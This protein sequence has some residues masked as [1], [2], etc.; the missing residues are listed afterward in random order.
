MAQI[1][2]SLGGTS[3]VQL[4]PTKPLKGRLVDDVA[5]LSQGSK[6]PIWGAFLSPQMIFYKLLRARQL[7][8]TGLGDFAQVVE[9]QQHAQQNFFYFSA[10]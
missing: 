7:G 1:V 5:L 4:V 6:P 3:F 10:F 9:A 2:E 8:K